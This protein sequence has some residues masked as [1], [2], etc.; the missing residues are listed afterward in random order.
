MENKI[1]EEKR[2]DSKKNNVIIYNLKESTML[3]GKERNNEDDKTC[4]KILEEEM[5]ITR[6]ELVQTVRLGTKNNDP[7][8]PRPLLVKL[9]SEK[10]KWAVIGKTIRLRQSKKYGII[11][12]NK[13][14]TKDELEYEKQLRQ[15]LKRKRDNGEKGWKIKKERLFKDVEENSDNEVALIHSDQIFENS[16]YHYNNEKNFRGRGRGRGRKM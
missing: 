4:F 16:T 2:R 8:K 10:E 5:G 11:Y 1:E 7:S 3:E 6:F 15:E 14:M 9:G 12:I 13:D